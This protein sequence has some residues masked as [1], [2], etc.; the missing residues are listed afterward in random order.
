MV[1]EVRDALRAGEKRLHGDVSAIFG[2]AAE[3]GIVSNT[4]HRTLERI[5]E[6][7]EWEDEFSTYYGREPALEGLLRMKPDPYNLERAM[8]GLDTE[9]VLFV[10]DSSNDVDAARNVGVDSAFLRRPRKADL[11]LEHR[12]TYEIPSLEELSAIV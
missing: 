6:H 5:V 9:N 12:P 10:G 7:F 8:A 11:E 3:F 2:L 4:Q 1:D